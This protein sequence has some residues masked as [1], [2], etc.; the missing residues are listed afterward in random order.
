MLFVLPF[1]IALAFVE[2]ELRGPIPAGWHLTIDVA[3]PMPNDAKPAYGRDRTR[4]RSGRRRLW[5]VAVRAWL[6][7][8]R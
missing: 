7:F 3:M 5:A 2:V 4:L 8:R 1:D 6:A